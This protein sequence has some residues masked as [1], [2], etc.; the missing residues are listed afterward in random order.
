LILLGGRGNNRSEPAV[1]ASYPGFLI[2]SSKREDR[3]LDIKEQSK[4]SRMETTVATRAT[5]R[6]RMLAEKRGAQTQKSQESMSS[7]QRAVVVKD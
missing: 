1:L 2:F 5:K 6:E 3:H 4:N 7:L